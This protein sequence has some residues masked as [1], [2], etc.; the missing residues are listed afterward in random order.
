LPVAVFSREVNIQNSYMRKALLVLFVI[1]FAIACK[2]Q[3]RSYPAATF[4]VTADNMSDFR[5]GSSVGFFNVKLPDTFVLAPVM[6]SQQSWNYTDLRS[7]GDYVVNYNNP[8]AN[9]NFSSAAYMISTVDTFGAGSI[10]ATTKA[11]YYVENSSTGFASLGKTIDSVQLNYP[12]IPGSITYP[13]QSVVFS[14]KI[15]SAKYPLQLNDS[16]SGSNITANY[17]LFVDAPTLGLSNVAGSQKN[18]INYTNTVIASGYM[19]LKGYA[20]T[21]PVLVV[22]ENQSVKINYFI[23]GNAAPPALLSIAGVTDGEVKNSVSYSFY[24]PVVG[25]VGTSYMDNTNTFVQSARFRK[26]F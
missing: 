9:A 16:W 11:N 19:N 13:A 17:N 10:T 2:K 1:V 15:Y 4:T 22:R 21:I 24:S 14:Q 20:S 25:Y 3:D 26:F 7:I 5:A 6:G 8:A 23:G 12:S 18:T